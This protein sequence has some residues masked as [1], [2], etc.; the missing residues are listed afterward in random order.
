MQAGF[1][2]SR[3]QLL[4]YGGLAVSEMNQKGTCNQDNNGVMD[5]E[6]CKVNL[7]G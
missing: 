2:I 3:L 1:H 6:V 5:E 7:R 4:L